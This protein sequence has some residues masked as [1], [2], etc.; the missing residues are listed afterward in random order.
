MIV[1]DDPLFRFEFDE[2]GRILR[3]L[4]SPKTANMTDQDFKRGKPP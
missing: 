4:W 2:K 1:H 3:F